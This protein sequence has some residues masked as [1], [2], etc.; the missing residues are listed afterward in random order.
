M[1]HP[2]RNDAPW[3]GRNVP[4]R[5]DTPLLMGR[6]KF[7]DDIILPRMG[8]IALL[9]SPMAHAR[10]M[11]IDTTAAKALPGVYCVL[12]GKEA[13]EFCGA[14]PT[15]STEPIVQHC[16]AVEKVRHV[17]EPVVAVLARNRYIAEDAVGMID[18]E[19]EPLP[20]IADFET[21]LAATGDGLVHDHLGTNVIAHRHYK[22]GPVDEAFAN[23]AHVTQRS[24]R[25]PRVGPQPIE[26][27]AA[28]ADYDPSRGAFTIY[29]NMSMNSILGGGIA[30][31]LGV[32]QRNVNFKTMHAGGS[33]GGKNGLTH[34]SCIAA[35]MA[36]ASGRPAKYIEDRLEHM[37]NGNQHA[38]ERVYDAALA[39]DAEGRFTALRLRLLDDYGAYLSYNLGSQGNA[40]AQAIGPY[41]IA[42]LEY[43]VKAVLTNKT[44]QAPYRGFGG[45]VANFVLERLVDAAAADLGIDRLE[46]RRQNFISKDQ[47]PYRLPH[48]NTYDS[49]DYQAVLDEA[50]RLADLPRFEALKDSARA[51]GKRIGIGIA[52]VNERSVLSPT[53]VWMLDKNP[54]LP[55]TSSPES[56]RLS[57]DMAGGVQ[58]VIF[59]PHWG[60]SPETMVIQLVAEHMSIEPDRVQ[61]IYGDTDGGL[62]SFG[63]AGSR[64]TVMIAGAVAGA[65]KLLKEK[66]KLR[67]SHLLGATPEQIVIHDGTLFVADAPERC[68][69]LASLSAVSRAM[70]LSFPVGE[71][72]SSGL[73][74]DFTYD[75]PLATLPND[76]RSDLGI[77]YPIVGHACHIVVIETDEGTGQVKFLR[78]VAVHDA[79]TVV[80][81]KLV[82]GQ[83]R[84]GVAQGIGTALYEQYQYD[85]DGQLLT[86][87]LADYLIPT[88][89]EIP[90]LIIGHIETP[91]PLTEFGIKGCGE[92]G[93]LAS[94]PAI[95]SAIDDAF[96][97]ERLFVDHLPMTPSAL[98]A[99]RRAVAVRNTIG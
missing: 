37:S 45:E 31:S 97:D 51:Q 71:E 33:F 49:G 53:E 81:P 47:F 70:R 30:H 75:H 9:A 65:C 44:Q 69:D 89:S 54:A 88:A 52:T 91:S 67:A 96:A 64:F 1:Q 36:R 20:V 56:I 2:Q 29:N 83:I 77:F 39:I 35:L 18:V 12:T 23:A 55:I 57:M 34:L 32:D 92:G 60:N 63:P 19:Y 14:L 7:V 46:L 58:A 26:T 59:A 48:G 80:N 94:I 28:A 79:G 95:A 27:A 41:Q 42:A 74:V 11:R 82:D 6:G 43:D 90:D 72:F 13:L 98:H 10:I 73:S 87:S 21:A 16:I 85:R 86:G 38:S 4:R 99:L 84:G 61:V 3:I 25:W 62:L 68:I 76:D 15:L 78:Y 22:W 50:L 93:R 17:G 8:H 40:L 5:E 24:F 66:L